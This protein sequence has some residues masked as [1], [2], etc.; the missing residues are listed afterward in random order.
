M[1]PETG[2]SGL[3][4]SVVAG[5]FAFTVL[6]T[7]WVAFREPYARAVCRS[8]A[9]MMSLVGHRVSVDCRQAGWIELQYILPDPRG[10]WAAI[11][12]RFLN[13]PDLPVCLSLTLGFLALP[14]RKRLIAA[15]VA[16]S[17]V[18]LGHVAVICLTVMR[19][20]R[21]LGLTDATRG[22][23]EFLTY[24]GAES[25]AS[26][27]DVSVVLAV[28]IAAIAL[29]LAAPGK[30]ATRTGTSV[31]GGR[32]RRKGESALGSG[33]QPRSRVGEAHRVESTRC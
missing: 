24:R 27:R 18:C 33:V 14:L 10:G 22:E 8:A 30:A 26:V 15:L 1:E 5:G 13:V 25:I 31:V 6:L 28:A 3:A 7:V 20:E 21:V 17:A 11:P 4:R 16:G 29:A 2:R 19:L 12:Q 23:R 9:A 32:R